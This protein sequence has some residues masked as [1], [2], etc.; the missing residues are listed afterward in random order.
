MYNQHILNKIH[1]EEHQKKF[2]DNS[3]SV[4]KFY[5]H[6]GLLKSWNLY[7]YK[8]NL[9]ELTIGNTGEKIVA[10]LH[11][12]KQFIYK[13]MI[14]VCIYTSLYWMRSFWSFK[15]ILQSKQIIT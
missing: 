3:T 14:K 1:D 5:M 10:N 7:L 15:Q 6:S 11:T 4:S 12:N 8:V 13:I 9:T 2:C